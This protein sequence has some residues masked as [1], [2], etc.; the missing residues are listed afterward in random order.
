MFQSSGLSEVR[1]RSDEGRTGG[2]TSEGKFL[3]ALSFVSFLTRPA[4]R[5]LE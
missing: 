1:C 4:T 2:A 3:C 5:E